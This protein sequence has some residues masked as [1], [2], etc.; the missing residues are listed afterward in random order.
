MASQVIP[1]WR[2]FD[3]QSTVRRSVQR[4][5]ILA[6]TRFWQFW[7]SLS[8]PAPYS[9][10]TPNST[11]GHPRLKESAE[12]RKPE[13]TQSPKS[14]V[15]RSRPR[16]RDETFVPINRS[17]DHVRSRRSCGRALRAHDLSAVG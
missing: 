10:C 6:I 5:S 17:P 8:S 2:G 3:A 4:L 11:Q 14:N 16:L 12:G 9:L 13:M 15:E 7:Q 1:D